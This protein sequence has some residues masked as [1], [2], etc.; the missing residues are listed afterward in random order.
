MTVATILHRA[1]I[2]DTNTL[3]AHLHEFISWLNERA[4]PKH[5]TATMSSTGAGT[6]TAKQATQIDIAEDGDVILVI[7]TGSKQMKLRVFSQ[8]MRA[9]SKVFNAMFGDNWSEGKNLS[10]KKPTQI[11]LPEDDPQAM[12]YICRT[13]HFQ[14][15]EDLPLEISPARP[16]KILNIAVLVNKYNLTSVFATQLSGLLALSTP[17]TVN[18]CMH[19]FCAARLIKFGQSESPWLFDIVAKHVGSYSAFLEKRSLAPFL[20]YSD[21]CKS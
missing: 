21:L 10:T 8:C 5:N 13:L 16:A 7:N 14:K 19:L 15:T 6:N 9:A 11:A 20:D 1:H 3:S 18:G 12:L 2:M 17:K 4:C